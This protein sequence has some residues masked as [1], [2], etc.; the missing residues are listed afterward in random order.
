MKSHDCDVTQNVGEIGDQEIFY[1]VL[2]STEMS[3]SKGSV[4][5]ITVAL[6]YSKACARFVPQIIPAIAKLC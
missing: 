1:F 4:N 2:K 6:G 5:N 3:V